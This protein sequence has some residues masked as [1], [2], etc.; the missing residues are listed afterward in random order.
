LMI[1][2]IWTHRTTQSLVAVTTSL[3]HRKLDGNR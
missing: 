3:G 1:P 2:W